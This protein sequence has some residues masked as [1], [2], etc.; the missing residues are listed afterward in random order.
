MSEESRIKTANKLTIIFMVIIRAVVFLGY[1]KELLEKTTNPV[2]A[3]TICVLC[4]V[5]SVL[6]IL[7]YRKNKAHP[8]LRTTAIIGT[9]IIY[10]LAIFNTH[11]DIMY[12]MAFPIFVCYIIYFDVKLLYEIG[13][14]IALLNVVYVV[15][16]YIIEKTLPSGGVATTSQI[17]IHI[18][19]LFF[20]EASIT[21][22]TQKLRDMN[23]DKL[24]MISEKATESQNMLD[25]V[26]RV[27]KIVNLNSA[28]AAGMIE[29]LDSA[30]SST[31]LMLEQI[32]QANS[33]NA[34]SIGD[35]TIQT[36]QIQEQIAVTEKMTEEMSSVTTSAMESVN[37]GN[38]SMRAL[39]EQTG[40]MEEANRTAVEYMAK[41]NENAKAVDK[42]MQE[43]SAISGQTNLLALN[44][45]IESARAGEAGRG[46]AVVADQVRLL[47]E[48]TK[49]LTTDISD[50]VTELITNAD[51]TQKVINDQAEVTE[52]E[53]AI[54]QD[55]V[56]DF[57]AI[58]ENVKII[59]DNAGKVYE[60]VSGLMKANNVIVDSINHIS[61]VS[62][63]VTASTDEA[64][65]LGEESKQKADKA[66]E[67]MDE[68]T[69]ASKEL[70][71][72]M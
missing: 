5:A 9:A 8:R 36:G 32:A 65:R 69:N 34:E 52:Q 63:E 70:D 11:S 7:L 72:Y 57:E 19:V 1:F 4:I 53:K 42:M 62:E 59:S 10:G 61:A 64:V 39:A 12:T 16:F 55:T 44:A 18:A 33:T 31:A 15:K 48:Q 6:D 24:K 41:L 45:S 3:I 26:L 60:N 21:F 43:I 17:L 71:K 68:L 22:V 46:F 56:K 66:K 27:A 25:D 13:A 20:M 35:Q 47:S 58:E 28:T 51:L 30:T 49:Q 23:D 37:S 67:L 14:G 50:I 54:V 2:P 38:R 40:K 29:D